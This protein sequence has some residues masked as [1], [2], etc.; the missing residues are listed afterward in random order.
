MGVWFDA[1]GCVN[2]D[3]GDYPGTTGC[4]NKAEMA[5]SLDDTLVWKI[6]NAGIDL[7]GN[8]HLLTFYLL[9][10][11]ATRKHTHNLGSV[12]TRSVEKERPRGPDCDDLYVRFVSFSFYHF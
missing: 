6:E 7:E 5:K 1:Q 3:H 11:S 8:D 12:G 2:G 10:Q 9:P 4:V